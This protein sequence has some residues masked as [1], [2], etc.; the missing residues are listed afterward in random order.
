MEYELIRSHRKTIAIHI[1]EGRVIVRAPVRATIRDVERFVASKQAWIEKHLALQRERA[2]KRA[3]FEIAYGSCV[4]FLGREYRI[5]AI[6]RQTGHRAEAGRQ[7]QKTDGN[8]GPAPKPGEARK[9]LAPNEYGQAGAQLS[10]FEEIGMQTLAEAS[11]VAEDVL[12]FPPGL[13]EPRLRKKL[14]MFYREQARQIL[15]ERIGRFA[16]RMGVHPADIRIGSAKRSWGSCTSAGRLTFSWRLMMA[17]PEA[18][19]YVIVHELAHLKHLNHSEAFWAVV[20]RILPDW[21][22]RRQELRLLQRRLDT[23]DWG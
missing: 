17:S 5:A 19:D 11:S 21:K 1:K 2:G 20:A 22:K 12:Y 4:L 7:K 23:E 10:M 3:G 14:I 9:T 8:A 15:S 16:T 18:V 6:G 13:D